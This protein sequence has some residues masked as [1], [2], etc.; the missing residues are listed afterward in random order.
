MG[1]QFVDR[2]NKAKF[3]ESMIELN[4]RRKQAAQIKKG[5]EQRMRENEERYKIEVA[6]DKIENGK[7]EQ[8]QRERELALLNR[9]R[10]RNND[11]RKA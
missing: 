7:V 9:E 8:I 1:R 3:N 11:H 5:F 4:V 6:I 2:V 10:Q